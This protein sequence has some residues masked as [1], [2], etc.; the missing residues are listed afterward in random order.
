MHDRATTPPLFSQ[1]DISPSAISSTT[2]SGEP[3]QTRL[4]RDILTAQDR[5]NELLEELVNQLSA[6][7]KQR[8]QEL[9]QWKSANPHLAQNCRTAAETLSRVQ[10]EFLATLT[11][12][13][14]ENAEVLCDGE[15]MLN[16]FVDRFGPRLAHL[17]GVLQVLAQLSAAPANS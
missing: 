15:F 9:G 14:N 13:V 17:N 2:S 4:L 6:P 10:T 3:E 1:V 7:H 8:N 5:Q 11:Q 16:E 12:E